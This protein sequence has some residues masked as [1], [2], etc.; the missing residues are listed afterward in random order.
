MELFEIGFVT[1]RLI[2]LLDISIVA[3]LFF[4]LYENLRGRIAIRVI[5]LILALF[6]AWKLVAL[7]DFRLLTSI[8]GEV[9]GLGA[10]AV[11]VIFAPEIRRFLSA[12]TTNPILD[13][14]LRQSGT[15]SQIEQTIREVVEALKSLR[16]TGNGAIIVLT[17]DNALEEIR[18][19]GDTIDANILARMI[20]TI[21]Q[22][23]SPLHDGAMILH[24]HRITSVR[25]IL[26]ISKSERL[27]AEL[28]LRH[29]AAL[30]LSEV[31]DALILI[32]S[33][34]RREVSLALRGE[35]RRNVEYKEVEEAMNKHYNT[36]AA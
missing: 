35:L 22:K 3:F 32:V 16:A 9:I 28:G 23:E 1:V 24:Q 18:E 8:M 26:P 21:F 14:L 33:E 11:V 19:T 4:K 5:S 2:D 6:V 20:F 15:G 30:G 27:D 10:I 29:R 34:E 25:A 12:F 31:S 7:L 17:G 36:V 13:R